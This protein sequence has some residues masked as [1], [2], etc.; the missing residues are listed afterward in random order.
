MVYAP[1][2]NSIWITV[3]TKYALASSTWDERELQAIQ[4]VIESN[5]FT[6]GRHVISLDYSAPGMR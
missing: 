2:T 4:Q 5:M 1:L 3:M 6:M